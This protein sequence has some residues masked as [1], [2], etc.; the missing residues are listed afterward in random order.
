MASATEVAA[1]I[2]QRHIADSRFGDLTTMKLHKLLYAT[3]GIHLA[4]T[5]AN[6][7]DDDE[8]EAWDDGPVAPT[9]FKLFVGRR[10]LNLDDLQKLGP[11]D[12]DPSVSSAIDEALDMY[13]SFSGDALS[14]ISHT[15]APWREAYK[16]GRNS[17]LSRESM[18][19]FF[20]H[21]LAVSSNAER[22]DAAVAQLE[23][24]LSTD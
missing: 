3:Q 23:S 8:M 12:V 18:A 2:L 10:Y 17:P 21:A 5:G 11:P 1:V 16:Q 15:E 20:T 9:V 19:E 4:E 7:F 14:D 22:S 6:A 24:L 13:G